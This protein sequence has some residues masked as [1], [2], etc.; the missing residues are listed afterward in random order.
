MILIGSDAGHGGTDPGALGEGVREKDQTLKFD[1]IFSR[2]MEK[3]K[4]IKVLR[5]R[6]NDV[7]VSLKDRA[8]KYNDA[9]V[10]YLISHHMNAFNKKAS[11]IEVLYTSEEGKK[12]AEFILQELLKTKVFKNNRGVKRRPGLYMLKA[13]KPVSVIIEYGFI[14]NKQEK[15]LVISNLDRLARASALGVKKYLK[16]KYSF[17]DAPTSNTEVKPKPETKPDKNQEEDMMIIGKPTCD[18]QQMRKWAESKKA[19]QLFIDLADTFYE[20]SVSKGI[21][22]AV[23]Y[24]QSAKETGYMKF[25]GVLDASFKNPCGLKITQGGGDKDKNAHKRFNTWKEG[26]QAQ[27]DHLALYAGQVGYPDPNSPDPRHFPYLHGKAKTVK[28]LGGK[29]APSKEYGISVEKMAKEIATMEK[30]RWSDIQ[31]SY[32]EDKK[33]MTGR[34][35]DCVTREELATVVYRILKERDSL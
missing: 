30:G 26:I 33:Y 22:P 31:W 5:T 29:W 20:V 32:V 11:G 1:S 17:I 34:P 21:D 9:G 16:T 28:D 23:T 25:G 15:D 14:D 19:N 10:N 3:D 13:T 6:T 7:Y 35:K 12:M 27:V 24:A 18:I 2:E 8:K 4:N